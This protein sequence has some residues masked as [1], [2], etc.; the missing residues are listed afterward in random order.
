M[1]DPLQLSAVVDGGSGISND[2]L[3]IGEK[4]VF[5]GNMMTR[6]GDMLPNM[7][8]SIYALTPTPEQKLVGSAVTGIDGSYSVTWVVEPYDIKPA[9]Q[10]TSKSQGSQTM[11]I[12]ATFEGND[13]FNPSKSGDRNCCG[14]VPV[15]VKSWD[16]IVQ[17]ESDKTLYE[18]GDTATVFVNFIQG[19]RFGGQIDYRDFVA[20]DVIKATYDGKVVELQKK[21]G[22]YTLDLLRN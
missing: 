6:K 1:L 21:E 7:P 18:Q 9:L 13:T 16:L 10:E 12:F 11:S 17:M 14:N 3:H 20:P 22:I 2:V 19:D 4:I 5:T 15:N 8:V